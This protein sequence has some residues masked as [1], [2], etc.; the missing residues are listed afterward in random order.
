VCCILRRRVLRWRLYGEA[1]S[2][3]TVDSQVGQV[4][5]LE[6]LVD[7]LERRESVL[8]AE[9]GRTPNLPAKHVPAG[10]KVIRE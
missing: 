8:I 3:P 6:K 10:G 7:S 2:A 1:A 5:E 9:L 4:R